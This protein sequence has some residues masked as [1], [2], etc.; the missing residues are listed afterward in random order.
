M[1]TLDPASPIPPAEQIR[2][3]L[4]A[5]VRTG[6]L[7]EDTR[8]PTVRQL[9]ADLR[10]A[11]GTVAKAYKEL[12]NVGLIRTGRAAGTRVNSGYVTAP[13]VLNAAQVFIRTALDA[14]LSLDEAQGILATGWTSHDDH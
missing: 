12:E 14:G 9:A 8:L 7:V 13:P 3:Q 5:L 2:S 1:I 6:Q 4:A 11:A 10:V